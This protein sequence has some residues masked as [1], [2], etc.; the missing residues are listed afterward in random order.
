[1]CDG[2]VGIVVGYCSVDF[3]FVGVGC[4]GVVCEWM[5]IGNGVS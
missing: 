4:I 1:M 3:L 2:R 5:C